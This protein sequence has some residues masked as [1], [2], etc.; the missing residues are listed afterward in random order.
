MNWDGAGKCGG[1]GPYFWAGVFLLVC[2]GLGWAAEEG[3]VSV[4]RIFREL[5]PEGQSTIRI[6]TTA[7]TCPTL[8][9]DGRPRLM[10]LRV[11]PRLEPR[12]DHPGSIFPERVCEV[13]HIPAA[14]SV[15]WQ[16]RI[17]PALN[18][19]PRK[20][21]VLGDTGCRIK[22]PGFY[23]SC[24]DPLQWPLA[25]VA[26]S[27]AAEHPDLVLHVGDYAYRES[28]CL[29]SGCAG[30]PHGYG[31]DV[32]QADFFEPMA[33]LLEAA[34]WV[35]V[36]GNHESCAR[37]G[38]G[39]F[40]Y[41]DPFPYDPLHSC[42][43]SGGTK[44]A[45]DP[46]YGVLLGDG[47]QWVVMDSTAVSEKKPRSGNAA[48]E[49][50]FRQFAQVARLTARSTQNWLT[51]HHPVLGYGYLPL[52]GYEPAN[53]QLSEALAEHHYPD[54][55]PPGVQLVVQG[56][57]HT[58]ELSRFEGI[59]TLGLIAGFGGSMLEPPFPGWVPGHNE[60]APGVRV[61][62]S[63]NDQHYG[64]LLMERTEEGQWRLTEKNVQG[65]TRRLCLLTLNQT[66]VGFHCDEVF[67]AEKSSELPD[68]VG[69]A[70]Y[71]LL[72]EVH[73]N[74]AGHALRQHWLESL[75][76]H[77]DFVLAMEQLNRARQAALTEA[78]DKVQGPVVQSDP[79]LRSMAEAGGFD[80]KGWHWDFY[81]PAL[82]LAVNQHWP[83]GATNLDRQSLMKLMTGKDPL[84]SVPLHWSA[85]QQEILTAEI[86]E[87]HCHLLPETLL[88]GMVAAQL[89]RDR[90]MAESLVAWHHQT[91]KP[92]ILLAGN[93]HLR[94]DTAVPQWL[95]QLDPGAR[96]VSVAVL[97]PEQM[98]D[99][100]LVG[101]YDDTFEVPLQPRV[102][103]CVALRERL[104]GKL[105]PPSNQKVP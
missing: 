34:P 35:V 52:V 27:A 70:D 74:Q 40:R 36:R 29:A 44:E 4:D 64:Y 25:Q 89:A 7:A 101:V 72:G 69:V 48:V 10:D 17:L 68:S 1:M 95:Q 37:A 65:Q 2:P 75:A 24:N 55:T 73:D 30:T 28:P 23:Q 49:T 94:K 11:G 54:W 104:S 3:A 62:Q 82:A 84:P 41:L 5:G 21:V 61:A 57:I 71:L 42:S 60:V 53:Y 100:K 19:S 66:P 77:G 93:G 96:V 8:V 51:L 103:P 78:D 83:L 97:E 102:D 14:A 32:W 58:F 63:Y 12:D 15:Q 33:P 59:S 86:R 38:Q 76:K 50:Y 92:V 90:S 98:H 18:H 16:G 43:V 56:H 20:I 105:S 80:F 45:P 81:A 31:E 46:P 99:P 87:G 22:W 9:V 79:A 91:G 47:L 88:P 39:W 26:H 67:T 6:L 13:T 85:H